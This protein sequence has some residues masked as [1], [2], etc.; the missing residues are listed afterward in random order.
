M[1]TADPEVIIRSSEPPRLHWRSRLRELRKFREILLNIIRKELKVKYTS[2]ILGAVWSM[3]NPLVFL[4][5]FTLVFTVVLGNHVPYFP[6]YLLSGL[7]AWNLFSTSLNS[8]VRSVIDNANLVKKV[9]FPREVLPL[10]SIGAALVDFAIQGTVL[11]VFMVAL[12]YPFHAANLLL[13]P[14]A[15]VALLLFTCAMCFLVA[16]INV[17]YRDT[18]HLLALL[19]LVWFWLTPVVYPSAQVQQRGSQHSLFGVDLFHL[20]LANPLAD[21]MYGFQ[22]ALYGVVTPLTNG[23]PT[24][25]LLSESVLW[26]AVLLVAVCIFSLGFLYLTWRLF[27]RLAGDFAE[28]L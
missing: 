2:S 15:I 3:V 8:A 1:I 11:I 13:L 14:L 25:I 24:P 28:E 4:G 20:Y 5:V 12:G 6:V 21:I 19:L 18:Q 22:R 26:I 7:L 27:F 16:G 17:H 10:S 23:K 9:Y